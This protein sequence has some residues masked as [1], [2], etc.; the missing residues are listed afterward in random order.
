MIATG[1][2]VIVLAPADSKA[3][4]PVV[5]RAM[6]QGIVVDRFDVSTTSSVFDSPGALGDA[7]NKDVHAR[8]DERRAPATP[9]GR[10]VERLSDTTGDMGIETDSDLTAVAERRLDV[11]V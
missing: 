11:R 8:A 1:V 2:D 7:S 5:R 10:A 3:M 4:I 9:S 6:A